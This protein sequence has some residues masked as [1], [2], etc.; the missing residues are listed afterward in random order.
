MFEASRLLREG[1]QAPFW[2]KA[3][4]QTAAKGRQGRVW[5]M[6]AG[7][8]AATLVLE[9]PQPLADWALRSFTMSLALFEALDELS[10]YGDRLRLKWPNDVLL[11]GRKLC[12][13]L[14]ETD[15]NKLLI[16]VGVNLL[17]APPQSALPEGAFQPVALR[18]ATG[19]AILPEALLNTLAAAHHRWEQCLRDHGFAPV[20]RAWLERAFNL[21]RP[22]TARLPAR[23]VTGCFETIDDTGAIVIDTGNGR[24]TLAAAE[25]HFA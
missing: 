7:N 12:G 3:A 6:A 5:E 23:N 15:K 14:L 20:R 11:D 25:L 13:I 8:F 9:P 21:K 24:V 4:H 17:G 19:C 22:V 16:G 18:P 10:G 2:V 1:K